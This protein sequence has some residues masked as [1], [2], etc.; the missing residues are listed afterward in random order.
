MQR[1]VY[2]I[3]LISISITGQANSG[4]TV[5]PQQQNT[6]HQMVSGNTGIPFE[7]MYNCFPDLFRKAYAG[8]VQNIK[9][10]DKNC[11][12]N[13][14]ERCNSIADRCD[15]LPGSAR[16]SVTGKCQASVQYSVG[17]A[18][19]ELC[20]KPLLF[21]SHMSNFS[22]PIIQELAVVV[23]YQIEQL[24]N[25][26]GG[27]SAGQYSP[28]SC[29][30]SSF[31]PGKVVTNVGLAFVPAARDDNVSPAELA[32]ALGTALNSDPGAVRGDA[33]GLRVRLAPTDGL[34]RAP[35]ISQPPSV[36][37]KIHADSNSVE[38]RT[39]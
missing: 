6:S 33:G 31:S 4:V 24:L 15:C 26:S 11:D 22:H 14:T 17:L 20:G 9:R 38:K 18:V 30:P 21:Q 8:L 34:G 2:L 23:C 12:A 35:A 37:G 39:T 28:G 1:S 7:S 13:A 29:Y 16:T 10:C 19:A 27:L 5:D 32:T 25:K 3:L 36:G